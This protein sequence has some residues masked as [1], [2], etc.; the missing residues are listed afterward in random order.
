MIKKYLQFINEAK[1]IEIDDY[2]LH[3]EDIEEI[4]SE[5]YNDVPQLEHSQ[6]NME[7]ITNNDHPSIRSG[8]SNIPYAK[9]Q[10]QVVF[11]IPN[12]VT[13]GTDWVGRFYQPYPRK[14]GDVRR[15]FRTGEILPEEDDK[16]YKP[17]NNK[18]ILESIDKKMFYR[19]GY[20][21]TKMSMGGGNG[22]WLFFYFSKND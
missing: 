3:M 10:F 9:S 21:L 13:K 11:F 4:F 7:D 12:E 16:V 17:L 5:L 2:I 22:Y 1:S 6:V 18:E 15:H 14:K 20:N 8:V 19:I